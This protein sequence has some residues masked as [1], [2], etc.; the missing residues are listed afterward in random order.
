MVIIITKQVRKVHTIKMVKS[1]ILKP[2]N[3]LL[4]W[5]GISNNLEP[6]E[7]GRILRGFCESVNK[8]KDEINK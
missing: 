8:F 6:K 3:S 1:I 7:L 4:E 2:Y 5:L